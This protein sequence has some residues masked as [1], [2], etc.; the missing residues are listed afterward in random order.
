MQSK[1]NLYDSNLY[2]SNLLAALQNIS[3]NRKNLPVINLNQNN[4][5]NG[6]LRI[7]NPGIYKLTED[8]IFSP[9]SF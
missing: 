7:K 5:K 3:N 6:T 2:D 8:I 4:F 9:N 1:S